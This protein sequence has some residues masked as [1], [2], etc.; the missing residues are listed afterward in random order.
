MNQLQTELGQLRTAVLEMMD[1]TIAQLIKS[2]VAFLT[3]NLEI[4]QEVR[5]H[6]KRINAMELS[7]DRECENIIALFQPV[8]TDLR[9]LIS[10]LKVNS[11]LERI[12]DYADGIAHYVLLLPNPLSEAELSASRIEEMF[13]MAISM[14]TDIRQALD[15]EDTTL[16]RKVYK[17]DADLNVINNNA[18]STIQELI[19]K[20][21]NAIRPL[22][23]LFSAIRK[24]ERVGDHIKNI[25]EDTIFYIEAEVLK[26]KKNKKKI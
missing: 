24:V 15:E 12:G 23:F 8:A 22:L 20:D 1:L 11:N 9:F 26:H 16:A 21:N 4:A 13:N 2:K 17:K 7:I 19:I 14:L 25:A 6:E 10:M 5:H 3:Y 18:S